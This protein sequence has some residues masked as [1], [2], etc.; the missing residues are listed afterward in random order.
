MRPFSPWCHP[1]RFVRRMRK[2]ASRAIFSPMP[3]L[4]DDVTIRLASLDDAAALASLGR[5]TFADAF[6]AE[7]SPDD[8]DLFLD[9]TYTPALQQLELE[10]AALTY[11]LVEQAGRPVAFALLRAG[12]TSS[13]VND[14]PAIELQRFYVV[15][16]CHGTGVAQALMAAC[17]EEARRGG[18]RTLFL[19]V[20]ERNPRALRFYAAQQ[21]T[22]VGQKIFQVGSD[23]QQDLVLARTITA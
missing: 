8:L 4:P 22:V 20:W 19:G 23:P 12:G 10:D 9:A 3:H 2:V 16:T 6:G 11:L 7:N 21:F 1:R 17:V 14:L 13:F 18:A 5:R 15:Q